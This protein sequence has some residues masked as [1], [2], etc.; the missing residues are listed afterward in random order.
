VEFRA[1]V[2]LEP[3]ARPMLLRCSQLGESTIPSAATARALNLAASTV[4]KSSAMTPAK[5]KP[6][7]ASRDAEQRSLRR[8]IVTQITP[9]VAFYR[10]EEYHQGYLEKHDCPGYAATIR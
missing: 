1:E 3:D 2:D 6:W 10:A 7:A 5:R 4:R 9:A 8:Q